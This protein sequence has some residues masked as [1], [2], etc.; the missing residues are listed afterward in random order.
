MSH[1]LFIYGTLKRGGSNHEQLAGQEYLGEACTL[2]GHRLYDLGE[3]PGLVRAQGVADYVHGELWRV[4]GE[5][6]HQ[7]DRFEGVPEG[8]YR[9]SA[10]ELDELHGDLVVE[11]YF[12]LR[13]L[14]GRSIL[15]DG[16][17]A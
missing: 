15:A 6:L 9:R 14:S 7:L 16:R 11:T 8:L 4:S 1:L 12:Y 13:D 2:P 3:Y 10:I 5:C 17:W